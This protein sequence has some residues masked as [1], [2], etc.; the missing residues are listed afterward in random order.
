[1]SGNPRIMSARKYKRFIN[2]KNITCSMAEV[3]VSV[4]VDRS[5]HDQMKVHDEIN[6]S[7]V[8]RASIETRLESLE[9]IDVDRAKKASAGIDSLRKSGVF[10]GGKSS[11][12]IIREWRNKR[13]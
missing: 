9:K 3:T 2:T 11:T 12:T 13:K 5:L 7:S 6:W 10:D 1:M 4:R 8:L